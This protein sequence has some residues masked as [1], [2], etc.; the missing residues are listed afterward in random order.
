M[1]HKRDYQNT[2]SQSELE[3]E[4]LK[5]RLEKTEEARDYWQQEA[6]YWQHAHDNK[7]A[8]RDQLKAL[9]RQIMDGLPNT[10]YCPVCFTYRH[11][12]WCWYEEAKQLLQEGDV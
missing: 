8:Q 3:I 7:E 1:T 5:W 9:L 4:Q 6:E 10:D 2:K 12:P 11:K